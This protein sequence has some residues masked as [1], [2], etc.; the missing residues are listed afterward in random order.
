MSRISFFVCLF[1]LCLLPIRAAQGQETADIVAAD[2]ALMKGDCRGAV[3]GYL[4]AGM[5]DR[6]PRVIERA[7]Q[8]SRACRNLPAASKSADRLFE[9]DGENVE[10]L[11]LVGLVALETWRLDLA[12]KVY[13]ALL[14]KPDVE[15][16][17]ALAELLPELAEGDATHAAWLVLREVIPRETVSGQTLSALARIACNADDLGACLSL[18]EAA[19]AK[20]AGSDARTIR[21]ASAAFAAMGR[22]ETALAE[23]NLLVQGDPE[24]HRFA[25]VETLTALDRLEDAREE[26]LVIE[27]ESTPGNERVAAEA[28]RRLALLAL[29]TGDEAEAERRFGARLAADRSSGESLY[30]LALIAERKG[31]PDLA[32]Q[33]YRQ[34][35]SAG[36]GLPPRVRA[37]QLLLARDDR[38]EAMTILDQA[39][40]GGRVDAIEVEIVRSRALFDAGLAAAAFDALDRAL[41]RFP[42]H[43]NLLYQRAVLLDADDRTTEAVKVFER[44]L[45]MRPGDGNIQNALGYTLADRKRQLARAESLIRE[46]VT[47][48]PDSAAFIDS[49]GWVRFRRGDNKGAVS[50]LERAWRLSRE[51]EIGAHLGEALWASGDKSRAREIWARALVIAPESKPLRATIERLADEVRKTGSR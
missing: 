27:R 18:V 40:R 3:E 20:G 4:S 47:Q 22:E 14:S 49:L 43:P 31:L 2:Q 28:D 8:V 15:P 33:G 48:R 11:R 45:K 36:A 10:A 50:I 19:R 16:D 32:L 5:V 25:R 35:I 51:A 37:A 9:L 38:Q 21:M 44:L 6:N 39:L 17:R 26:L 42:D 13:G 24:N 30:Y 12:R 46:A 23:A 29:A 41:E 34:L 7:L 1:A